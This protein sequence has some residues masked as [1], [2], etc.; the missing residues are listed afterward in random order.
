MIC[1]LLAWKPALAG[2]QASLYRSSLAETDMGDARLSGKEVG[3]ELEW[4]LEG[5]GLRPAGWGLEYAYT[6][7]EYDNLPTRN[8]DL[9]R[10]EAPL[11][12]V[13]PGKATQHLEFRPVIATSSNVMKDLFNRGT[14]DDLMLQGRWALE[15]A[16]SFAAP[17]WRAGVAYDDAFGGQQLYP[18]LAALWRGPGYDLGLGWPRS[19]AS[20]QVSNAWRFGTELAPAGARWHVLSDE[21]DGATF[22]YEVE[23]WRAIASAH[24][25][26]AAGF[27][28]SA[29]A[30]LEFNRRHRFE[31]D[32]GARVNRE[33]DDVLYLELRIGYR[34]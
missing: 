29:Q 25:Q 4:P 15:S 30:G 16:P 8:R 22:D 13:V 10:V 3:F 28:L 26:T 1:C 33:A 32:E 12:W 34:W 9:H 27:L 14:S 17:G 7:Y 2:P 11:A 31:D 23:A 21:R 19:W 5:A 24:W 18:E 20:Y 6:R